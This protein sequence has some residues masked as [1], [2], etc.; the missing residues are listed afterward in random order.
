MVMEK[1]LY[2]ALT[3]LKY[4]SGDEE[5]SISSILNDMLK[6][7][8]HTYVLSKSMGHILLPRDIIKVAVNAMTDEEIKQASVDNVVRYKDGAMLE[9][10]RA[11]LAA[12]LELVRAFARANKFDLEVSKN[13]DNGNQVLI[14]SFQMGSKFSQFLGNTY[15]ILLEEF[16][17]IDRMEITET[18][19][20]F[21][22]KP[23]KEVVQEA[24]NP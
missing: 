7:Y 15:R 9:H 10:G 5:T 21:E 1:N 4:R 14:V 12:Y 2:R 24:K 17:D 16:V 22:Y 13:P 8:L 19:A 3:Q 20:Y 18:T 23:K 11:S 6:E